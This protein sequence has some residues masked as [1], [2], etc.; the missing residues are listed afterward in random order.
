MAAKKNN[1]TAPPPEIVKQGTV[2]VVAQKHLNESGAHYQ[3][4]EEFKTTPARAKALGALV[5][6]K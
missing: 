2:T 3:P 1:E 5:A 4:G 6:K